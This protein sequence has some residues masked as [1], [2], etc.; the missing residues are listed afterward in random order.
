MI[1]DANVMIAAVDSSDSH[2][3]GALHLLKAAAD[4]RIVAHRLT[5][6]EALVRAAAAGRAA[7]TAE[8]LDDIGIG[9]IDEPDD[10]VELATLRART[11]LRM[12]DCVVLLAARRGAARLATFDMR[13][14]EAAR[15]EGIAVVDGSVSEWARSISPRN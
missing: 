6:A 8:I 13:L 7:E 2:S 15:R 14:A 9:R 5:I 3:A 1:L 10:P 11:G 4:E 12:P